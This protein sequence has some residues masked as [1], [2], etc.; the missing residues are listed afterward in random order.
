M[1]QLGSHGSAGLGSFVLF[2]VMIGGIL[3]VLGSFESTT[4]GVCEEGWGNAYNDTEITG[5][6]VH[7]I[8]MAFMITGYQS[9]LSVTFTGTG[10][11]SLNG[12]LVGALNASTSSYLIP[13]GYFTTYSALTY[14]DGLNVSNSSLTYWKLNDCTY[15]VQ[16]YKNAE[17]V[18]DL[19]WNI[20]QAAG[21][22]VLLAGG[23]ILAG[24]IAGRR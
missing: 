22:L 3:L 8:T 16:Q 14:T 11:V 18:T 21:I 12:Y 6:G 17:I 23:L 9:N 5:G 7:G 20:M 15:P 1:T 4:I 13:D 24:F 19:N 10:N 2:I